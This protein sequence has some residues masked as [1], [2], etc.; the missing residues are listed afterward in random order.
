MSDMSYDSELSPMC[1]IV[2]H[3]HTGQILA[4]VVKIYMEKNNFSELMRYRFL[5][6]YLINLN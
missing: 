5:N 3:L 4:P 6:H 2:L 1:L